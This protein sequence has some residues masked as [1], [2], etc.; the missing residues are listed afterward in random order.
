MIRH[1]AEGEAFDCTS[2][3]FTR[4]A[5]CLCFRLPEKIAP[6]K[7]PRNKLDK[8]QNDG[9]TPAWRAGIEPT[10]SVEPDEYQSDKYQDQLSFAIHVLNSPNNENNYNQP[11]DPH[12]N[13]TSLQINDIPRLSLLSSSPKRRKDGSL[14]DRRVDRN[15]GY[16]SE[17][18]TRSA[19]CS[20]LPSEIKPSSVRYKSKT[21][22]RSRGKTRDSDRRKSRTKS[23]DSY[24]PT[25]RQRD[26]DDVAN[27][28][29]DSSDVMSD[30][31]Y[32]VARYNSRRLQKSQT[33]RRKSPF[34]DEDTKRKR[35][36]KQRVA[37]E[38]DDE[39]TLNYVTRL[40]SKSKSN[41]NTTQIKGERRPTSVGHSL[42]T[43][44]EKVVTPNADNGSQVFLGE[45]MTGSKK[46]I[47]QG[48]K[49][50]TKERTRRKR[51]TSP[52]PTRN[53]RRDKIDRWKDK[54]VHHVCE[55]KL[56]IVYECAN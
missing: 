13:Q 52:S 45:K 22:K 43:E 5:F 4:L 11:S 29:E 12:R 2:Y 27:A 35:K 38:S 30:S 46:D 50:Q 21:R 24:L 14:K 44:S 8:T 19:D 54:K 16:D 51:S 3:T 23:S 41:G 40:R 9:L 1:H 42:S 25:E 10:P 7:P 32:Y 28:H 48:H 15:S 37:H 49:V 55:R 18:E 26:T 36:E 34:R 17:Q 56:Y 33:D 53:N 20:T 6:A 47:K 39:G 31:E